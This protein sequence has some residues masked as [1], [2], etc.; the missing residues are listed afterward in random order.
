MQGNPQ[1]AAGV[2]EG[3][4]LAGKHRVERVL[5]V[6][7][8]GVV[9]AAH[10]VQLDEKVAIKSLLPTMLHNP[11]AGALAASGFACVQ[12]LGGCEAVLGV[13]SLRE[14]SGSGSENGA[15]AGLAGGASAGSA[16]AKSI[17]KA[18]PVA[19]TENC[20]RHRRMKVTAQLGSNPRAGT[21]VRIAWLLL[22]FASACSG[23]ATTGPADAATG[24]TTSPNADVSTPESIE[25]T[26]PAEADAPV[27]VP[28]AINSS[29]PALV[30]PNAPI[31]ACSTA[32]IQA[33]FETCGTGAGSACS[34]FAGDPTNS[35]CIK[36]MT[37]LST[38]SSYG[39]VILFPNDTT[40][41]NVAGCIA[42][43]DGNRS[44]TGCA[45]A[46]QS[47]IFCRTAACIAACPGG[48]DPA[49]LAAYTACVNQAE[50][51]VCESE[52]QAATCTQAPQYAGCI[53]VDYESEFRG[54]GAIFCA[55]Q[56]DGGSEAGFQDAS[57][58]LAADAADAFPEVGGE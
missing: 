49:G 9:V 46:V 30:P 34:D 55:A 18:G 17:G 22:G 26:A 33:Y 43:V 14:R 28:Q 54:L 32:Q 4:I 2:R 58:A 45:A 39:P 23:H 20:G 35:P 57:E 52:T 31:A 47:Q 38:A 41:A 51:T 13:G 48:A 5:G 37:S 56:A 11:E 19:C 15:S 21:G 8:M 3:Q 12:A 1:E 29:L 27:C 53:F 36:C 40:F 50:T 7:G 10:H 44:A 6:G 24:D 16:H 42:L 25:D